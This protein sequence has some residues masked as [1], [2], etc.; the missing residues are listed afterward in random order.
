M[1]R[2]D[3]LK[4]IGEIDDKYVE[5][6]FI[7]YQSTKKNSR[8]RLKRFLTVAA[9]FALI[10][11]AG[12]IAI[13][14]A[15]KINGTSVNVGDH[16]QSIPVVCNSIVMI[17]VNPS[18]TLE[19]N[20]RDQVVSIKAVND[21]AKEIVCGVD[22]VGKTCSEAVKLVIDDLSAKKYLSVHKNSIL[23]SVL[24][25]DEEKAESLRSTIVSVI[26]SLSSELHYGLSVLSQ[27]MTSDANLKD[28]ADE[29]SISSGKLLLIEKLRAETKDDKEFSIEKLVNSNVQIL[30]QLIA[31]LGMPEDVHHNGKT[32]GVVSKERI[33]KAGVDENVSGDALIDLLYSLQDAFEKLV[34]SGVVG[35]GDADKALKISKII[36]G[37][38]EV[39]W[40]IL[41]N[42]V[43]DG[44][45]DKDNHKSTANENDADSG[46]K[47][48]HKSTANENNADA[49][50]GKTTE[51]TEQMTE[52]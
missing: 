46:S 33:A 18:I 16:T 8:S 52:N 48:S 11:L 26:D 35:E 22:V 23:V 41:F 32:A 43:D 45:S 25:P 5:E 38:N 4:Y 3:L 27:S 50:N 28:T 30:N 13:G 7:E 51:N 9:C 15:T 37:N 29:Y 34:D 42:F 1:K 2:E 10:V 39:L 44:G 12:A 20:D 17:D 36:T 19:I 47:D 49:D 6:L 21:D 24:N 14:N 31:Y 40:N